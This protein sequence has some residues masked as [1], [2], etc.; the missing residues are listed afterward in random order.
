MSFEEEEQQSYF[1]PHGLDYGDRG[2]SLQELLG[3]AD[4]DFAGAPKVARNVQDGHR[5]VFVV[6]ADDGSVYHAWEWPPNSNLW[7]QWKVLGGDNNIRAIIPQIRLTRN[8]L[9]GIRV[10]IRGDRN[11]GLWKNDQVPD[12]RT[13][14]I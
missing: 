9:G 10:I 2:Q 6:G 13:L 4:F 7:S 8:A 3:S 5:E 12:R 14:T 11:R 1:F